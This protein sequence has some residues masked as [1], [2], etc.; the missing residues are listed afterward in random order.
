MII[1]KIIKFNLFINYYSHQKKKP[2]NHTPTS[3]KNLKHHPKKKKK[4][5]MTSQKGTPT[6]R[7]LSK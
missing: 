6:K 1:L 7:D 2:A 5:P 4:T 3:Q